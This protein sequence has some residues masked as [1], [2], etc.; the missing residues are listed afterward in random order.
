MS[1]DIVNYDFTDVH[2]DHQYGIFHKPVLE[3]INFVRI[4]ELNR[5]YQQLNLFINKLK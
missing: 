5:A 4:S 1:I 3:A 2:I